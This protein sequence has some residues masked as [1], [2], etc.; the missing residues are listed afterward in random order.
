[1]LPMSGSSFAPLFYQD[2][3]TSRGT[4][5]G[6]HV[7]WASPVVVRERAKVFFKGGEPF[8]SALSSALDDLNKMRTIRNHC[9]HHSQYATVQYK[10]MIRQV[11]GSGRRISPGRLLSSPPVSGLSPALSATSYTTVFHFY[12][13]ILSAAS[14][15]IVPEKT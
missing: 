10:K 8:E 7:K 4:N 13:E 1:V 14:Y 11:F 12:G 6:E 5:F 9:V 15:Q 3:L 2:P